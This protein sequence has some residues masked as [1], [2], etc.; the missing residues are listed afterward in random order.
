MATL[1]GKMIGGYEIIEEVGRGAMGVVFKAKQVSMDRVVAIKFLPKSLAQKQKLVQRFLREARAAGKLSHPNIVAVHDVGQIEGTYYI[2]ME[3]IDGT[4]AHKKMK[5]KGKFPEEEVVGIGLQIAAALKEAHGRGILH[6]DVKPDNFL[7][8]NGGRVRLA[9]LGLARSTENDDLYGLGASLYTLST[10]KTMFEG[11]TPATV[12]ALVIAE[13]HKPIR[14]VNP[15]LSPGFCNVVEKLVQK[16]AAKRYQS[17]QE[18]IDAL[19]KVRAGEAVPGAATTGRKTPV[20]PAKRVR[21]PQAAPAKA[22]PSPVMYIG[23]GV[24]AAVVLLGLVVAL[25]GGGTPSPSASQTAANKSTDASS[26]RSAEPKNAATP[27][28]APEDAAAAQKQQEADKAFQDLLR[29]HETALAADPAGLAGAWDGFAKTY[30]AAKQLEQAK[31]KAGEARTAAETQK[32]E[33]VAVASES[34]KLSADQKYKEAYEKLSGYAQEH[35]T[36]PYAADAQKKM[37][38]LKETVVAKLREKIEQA[39]GTAESG[40]FAAAHQVL[41]ELNAKAPA[42]LTEA[43]GIKQA[44]EKLNTLEAAAKS[45]AEE[46]DTAERKILEEAHKK[47]EGLT[48]GAETKFQF[49]DA[50]KVFREAA[51]QLSST[52]SKVSAGAWAERYDRVAKY[53]EAA[54][55]AVTSGKKPELAAFGSFPKGKATGWTDKGIGY[56]P[57]GYPEQLVTWKIV[58]PKH[59]LNLAMT[60]SPERGPLDAGLFAY[61]VGLWGEAIAYLGKAEG[62][63]KALAEEPRNRALAMLEDEARNAFAAGKAAY[64]KKDFPAVQK[65]LKPL[66]A[67]PLAETKTAKENAAEIQKM[68]Q[69]DAGVAAVAAKKEDAPKGT[70]GKDASE[71]LKKAGWET[72][73][74]E[75][76][77][78]PGKTGV[79]AVKDGK[80]K[81]DVKEGSVSLTVQSKTAVMEV[82]FHTDENALERAKGGIGLLRFGGN[83]AFADKLQAALKDTADGYGVKIEGGKAKVFEAGPLEALADEAP[84]F[85]GGGGGGGRGGRGRGGFGGQGMWQRILGE[86]PAK[87]Q[88]FDLSGDTYKIAVSAVNTKLDV[89]VNDKVH[90]H[91]HRMRDEGVLLIKISGEATVTGPVFKK[92]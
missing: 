48:R 75:W 47:A 34:D 32:K 11:N 91:T 81:V 9:D 43:A 57:E 51:G 49:A 52:G 10:G 6:R 90:S 70:E 35:A 78:V 1:T 38:A 23:I 46:A 80:L 73:E 58:P 87:A 2:S 77:A 83:A 72:V 33:W 28:S 4:T 41:E 27:A 54:K 20:G 19:E 86:A 18:V 69:G 44:F 53:W 26:A 55:A 89:Q 63:D 88:E 16:D 39:V 13:A 71:D 74:G 8:E 82:Y 7:I 14:Q 22:A 61:A 12:M 5:D 92:Q 31:A 84:S 64:E 17:A 30:P 68:L 15:D 21:D 67:G 36:G 3:F 76:K 79:F 40:D 29:R 65:E 24:G 25:K 62:A 85:G 56:A 42:A 45:K 37:E 60:A 50:A 66:T 59:A